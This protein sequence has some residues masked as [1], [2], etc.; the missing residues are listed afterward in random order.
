MDHHLLRFRG[1]KKLFSGFT[2]AEME[3]M[4]RVLKES[5]QLPNSEVIKK[6]TGGFNRSA[7]RAGKPALRCTEVQDWF[8]VRQQDLMSKDTSL[9][10]PNTSPPAQDACALENVN[11][12]SDTSKGASKLPLCH[13]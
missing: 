11:E 2:T 3:K 6:L 1:E 10:V 4:E 12:T 9:T 13:P 8:L 7:G 5:G